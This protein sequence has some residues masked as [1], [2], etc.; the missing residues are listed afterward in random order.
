MST[1]TAVPIDSKASRPVVLHV[2]CISGAGGGPEKTIL[3]SPRHL[4]ELGFE[5]SCAFLHPPGD[6]GF[7]VVRQRAIE[8]RAPLVG[9]P[10][11]GPLDVQSIRRLV[12]ICK[13]RRV[14]IWQSHD[15]KTNALGLIVRGFWP[16]KLVTMAH[17]WVRHTPRLR[18]YYA[19]D[20]FCLARFDEVICV[21][22]DLYD[23]CLK[24]G[25]P[26]HACHLV[27][28]A[29]DAESFRRVRDVDTAKREL[30]VAPE[31]ILV[32]AVG[33]LSDEKG[34]DLLVQAIGGLLPSHPRLMLWIAGEGEEKARLQRLIDDRGLQQHVR[35]LGF[36]SD[37]QRLFE[38]MDVYVCSS[39]RE[40][41]P[42]SVLEAMALET[43]VLATR[44]AGVPGVI[45]DGRNGVL[46]APGSAAA[47]AAGLE[48]LLEDAAFRARLGSAGRETVVDH[49][50]FDRRM[51]RVAAIYRHAL[52]ENALQ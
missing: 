52:G 27:H 32:G 7:E 47:L 39:I 42:N 11:R 31:T 50:S 5:A 8:A 44:I 22:E 51:L 3:N 21:S 25:V 13:E 28:N 4:H 16:M 30:G 46:V 34:F 26:E 19:V 24:I 1:L 29:I 17:G 40:G 18:L 2:R 9:I 20:R 15:Y 43:P 14:D 6:P 10:D 35:L 38:A 41:L 45:A 49:Y 12:K 36:V 37:V 23:T 33:R 48:R